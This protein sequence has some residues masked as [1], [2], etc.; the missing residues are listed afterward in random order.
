M[1]FYEMKAYVNSR[2]DLKGFNVLKSL[3]SIIDFP[4]FLKSSHFNATQSVTAEQIPNVM[5]SPLMRVKNASCSNFKPYQNH[6]VKYFIMCFILHER[7][8]KWKMIHQNPEGFS[9]A[10]GEKLVLQI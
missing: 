6:H 1:E 4:E 10:A 7:G 3:A 5:Q 8:K 2:V 9:V